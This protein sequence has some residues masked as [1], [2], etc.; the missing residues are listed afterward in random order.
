MTNQ[1]QPI[2][3]GAA[4]LAGRLAGA[5]VA[6]ALLVALLLI[7]EPRQVWQLLRSADPRYLVAALAASA[8]F[9]SAR[10]LRLLVLLDSSV[11][12]WPRAV[13]VVAAAQAAAHFAPMRTGEL[14][15]PWLLSR[16]TKRQFEAGIGTLVAAR[17]LDAATLG[18]WCGIAVLA[19][20]GLSEPLAVVASTVLI[21]PALL[22][23]MT[24]AGVDRFAAR[25]LAP[26]G[27][28]GRRW[29]RR[30][31]RVRDELERI[32]RQPGRMLAAAVISIVMWGLQWVVVGLLLLAIGYR[33]PPVDVVAGSSA[34]AVANLLPFTIMGGFGTLEAGW[35]AAFTALGIPLQEAAA[36]GFATHLWGLIFAALFG[37]IGWIVLTAGERR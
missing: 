31:R 13:L 26:R 27:V 34:A 1:A 5:A 25:V 36:S 23:P 7:A 28:A 15:L 17:T 4:T 11:L 3:N 21:L 35:T 22:L 10:G 29:A 18:V 2:G 16:T 33:W 30:I 20:L 32:R 9:L 19:V 6:V 24:V 37:L 12:G 14:A 8:A